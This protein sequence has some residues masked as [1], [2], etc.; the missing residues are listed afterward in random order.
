MR[1]GSP[2]Y[3]SLGRYAYG[4]VKQRR[5]PRQP[6]RR[7]ASEGPTISGAKKTTPNRICRALPGLI[8]EHRCW[9]TIRH[10]A[11][12][13]VTVLNFS[14]R[15]VALADGRCSLEEERSHLVITTA[16]SPWPEII[17]GQ[18]QEWAKN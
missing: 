1:F 3:G 12:S 9:R 2:P 7:R 5:S 11:F 17:P 15:L 6:A 8:F 16:L 4:Q 14:R 13:T 10:R 18:P